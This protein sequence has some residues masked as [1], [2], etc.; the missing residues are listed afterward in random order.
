MK[1]GEP[2]VDAVLPHPARCARRPLPEAE[3][4]DRNSSPTGRGR[5]VPASSRGE[6]PGE[7]ARRR[8]WVS[9]KAV[10]I[11]SAHRFGSAALGRHGRRLTQSSLTRL[12]SL[13][14][15]SRRERW[16]VL[17]MLLSQSGSDCDGP[18]KPVTAPGSRFWADLAP[19]SVVVAAF[20]HLRRARRLHHLCDVGG[21]AKR[22]LLLRRRWSSLPLAVLLAAAL[23]RAWSRFR[24]CVVRLQ[25]AVVAGGAAVLPGLLHPLG[26][27]GNAVHVLLLSRRVLQGVLGRSTQLRRRRAAQGLPG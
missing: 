27:R 2:T 22:P 6:E 21:L 24:S 13:A 12:A 14:D 17:G 18:R 26:P 10:C 9:R 1:P 7:G 20:R 3:V 15:L 16:G 23:G 5:F 25:A 4:S 8:V 11:G 19:G